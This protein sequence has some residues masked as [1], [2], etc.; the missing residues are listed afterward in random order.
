MPTMD[1]GTMRATRASET[2]D[3]DWENVVATIPVDLEATAR[4]SHAR[5]RRRRISSA[6]VL[7]RTLLVYVLDD[8]SLRLVATQLPAIGGAHLSAPALLLDSLSA[9]APLTTL[10]WFDDTTR[11]ISVWPWT[12]FWADG[13]RQAV[14]GH[15]SLTNRRLLVEHAR[16]HVRDAPRPRPQQAVRARRL[17]QTFPHIAQHPRQSSLET[18]H[19]APSSHFAA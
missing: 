7:L 1:P 5:T 6:A 12:T 14:H 18:A 2:G 8:A 9:P 4:V 17:P 16:R 10:A 11:P 13:P 15:L 3:V 19:H